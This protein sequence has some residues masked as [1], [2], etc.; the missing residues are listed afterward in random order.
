MS[1]TDN[2]D[3][4]NFSIAIADN[5]FV[6]M[7]G[8]NKIGDTI[9]GHAHHF[10]H[11]TLLAT[12]AVT[13]KHDNG[14]NEFKA[15]YLIVTPKHVVHEFIATQPNTTLCCIHAIRDG[16]DMEDV[17]PQDITPREARSLLLKYP[18]K[19]QLDDRRAYPDTNATDV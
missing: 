2:T 13:M 17:A 3:D 14:V 7:F 9:E 10:D 4:T 19:G 15:P 5:V 16:D 11:I 12:G 1:N 8:L 18:V 6:R